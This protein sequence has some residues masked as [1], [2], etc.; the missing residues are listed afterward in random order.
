VEDADIFNAMLLTLF[1]HA[2]LHLWKGS[3]AVRSLVIAPDGRTAFAGGDDGSLFTFDLTRDDLAVRV[4]TFP[5]G[6]RSLAAR[7]NLLA[8]GTAKGQIF[9]R[10][11]GDPSKT[12]R[13]LDA[14]SAVVSALAFQPNGPLLAAGSFDGFV[15]VWN[16]DDAS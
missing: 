10:D 11:L 2:G 16:I 13:P 3:D 5:G 7:G 4:G 8:V 12:V 15:R 9:L 1:D 6:V 14:G